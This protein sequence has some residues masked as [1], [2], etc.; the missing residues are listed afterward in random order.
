MVVLKN[1]IAIFSTTN[2]KSEAAM[3][4]L[5]LKKFSFSTIVYSQK[6]LCTVAQKLNQ[7]IIFYCSL[8]LNNI[9]IYIYIYICLLVSFFYSLAFSLFSSVSP[10]PLSFFFFSSLSLSLSLSLLLT[11][12]DPSTYPCLLLTQAP[13]QRQHGLLCF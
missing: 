2:H 11:L 5:E 12:T 8:Q 1:Y 7:Y 10:S 9:Y 3:V 6:W 13:A 4:E